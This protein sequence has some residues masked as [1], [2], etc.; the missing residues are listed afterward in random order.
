MSRISFVLAPLAIILLAAAIFFVVS[1]SPRTRACDE[2][3]GSVQRDWDA[4]ELDLEFPK[5]LE[6]AKSVLHDATLR[7][8]YGVWSA[9]G[10]ENAAFIFTSRDG[11]KGPILFVEEKR[12]SVLEARLVSEGLPNYENAPLNLAALQ[13][14]PSTVASL[15][16]T[17]FQDV[18]ALTMTLLVESCELRWHVKGRISDAT[19][20]PSVD[21]DGSV[22]DGAHVFEIGTVRELD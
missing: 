4:L 5:R 3:P 2:L 22:T 7:S 6:V 21:F 8:I 15:V 12:S 16:E 14:G 11:D 10:L 18:D 20:K 1:D 13:T 19:G 9:I 17:Q